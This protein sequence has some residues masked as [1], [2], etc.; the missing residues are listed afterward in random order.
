MGQTKP[1]N[2][3]FRSRSVSVLIGPYLYEYGT[4][5]TVRTVMELQHYTALTLSPVATT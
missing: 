4:A 2:Q 1:S 5:V 3:K